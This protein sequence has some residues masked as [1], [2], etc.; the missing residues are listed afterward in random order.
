[1]TDAQLAAEIAALNRIATS[2]VY[3]MDEASRRYAWIWVYG[4]TAREARVG[5][6]AP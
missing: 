5:R 1:M 6:D 3:C 4:G 2:R